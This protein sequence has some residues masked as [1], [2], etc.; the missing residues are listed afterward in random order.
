MF[1]PALKRELCP[2]L[3]ALS[4]RL[5]WVL[6]WPFCMKSLKLEGF[7][8]MFGIITV[9]ISDDSANCPFV[10]WR[11]GPSHRLYVSQ[12]R[13]FLCRMGGRVVKALRVWGRKGR[14]P[15]RVRIPSHAVL[16]TIF[17]YF[18]AFFYFFI[19]P[20][21]HP[22]VLF[23]VDAEELHCAS[24]ALHALPSH[25]LPLPRWRVAHA[26]DTTA[27]VPLPVHVNVVPFRAH[28]PSD[29]SLRGHNAGRRHRPLLHLHIPPTD[30]SHF[31][32]DKW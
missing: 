3:C 31:W 21:P 18:I 32:A 22:K 14:M 27:S 25:A 19:I 29:R 8:W 4:M 2:R 20:P 30:T 16:F 28:K 1:L 17:A 12:K 9:I 24:V 13:H 11:L 26:A 23:P 15:S 7:N 5:R 10:H 6:A